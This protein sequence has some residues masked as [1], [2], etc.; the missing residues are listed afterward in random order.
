MRIYFLQHWFNLS[1][2]AVEEAL[3]DSPAMRSFV[4]VD[5]GREPVPDETRP[6]RWPSVRDVYALSQPRRVLD[7]RQGRRIAGDGYFQIFAGP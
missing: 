3:Y 1:D 6:S 5:L 2:P 7:A 4:D